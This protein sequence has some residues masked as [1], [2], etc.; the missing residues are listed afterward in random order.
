MN[1]KGIRTPYLASSLVNLFKPENKSQFRLR[2]DLIS[3]KVNDFL[4]NDGIPVTLF[5]NTLIF[6]ESI[7]SFKLD[8]DLLETMTNYDFNV[9]LSNPKD[10][11]LIYEFAKE[12]KY[13]IRQKGR[14]SDR[15]RA[16]IKLLKSPAIM[17]AGISN[18]I[19]LSSDPDELCN[20]MK[21]LLQE[22]QAGNNSDLINQEIVAIVDKL[23]E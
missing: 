13:N 21:L 1:D 14:K 6:R 8:G 12:M 20:R 17:A 22:I 16:L 23:L 10:R 2:K 19:I 15:G 3:T 4:I 18:I 7:N 5:S 11:K 9:S